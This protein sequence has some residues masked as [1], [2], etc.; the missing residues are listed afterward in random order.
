MMGA[1]KRPWTPLA[2]QCSPLLCT[3]HVHRGEKLGKG[4]ELRSC[5]TGNRERWMRKK[6]KW[7][8]ALGCGK[9]VKQKLSAPSEVVLGTCGSWGAGRAPRLPSSLC[10]VI[11][12]FKA[13]PQYSWNCRENT[14][15][16]TLVAFWT[17]LVEKQS[18]LQKFIKFE[19]NVQ[20]IFVPLP[21]LVL[22]LSS[23]WLC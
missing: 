6:G 12:F 22:P 10:V 23:V 17:F 18:G 2:P 7:V 13:Y 16:Q 5:D 15:W 21:N 4:K 8:R 11:L 20:E 1:E 3:Q 9:C 14:L 19:A